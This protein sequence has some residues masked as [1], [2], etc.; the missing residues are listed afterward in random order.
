MMDEKKALEMV[1][2][3]LAGNV[4]II[5]LKVS[6]NDPDYVEWGL[7]LDGQGNILSCSMSD[8]DPIIPVDEAVA[9]VANNAH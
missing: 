3:L 4:D 8:Y 7:M 5:P 6:E 2:A 1:N 9:L